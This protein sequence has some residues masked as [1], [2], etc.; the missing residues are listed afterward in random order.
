MTDS[1]IKDAQFIRGARAMLNQSF[2]EQ[3]ESRR[4][5]DETVSRND[6]IDGE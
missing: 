6:V 5:N 3:F 1:T 4:E 2:V